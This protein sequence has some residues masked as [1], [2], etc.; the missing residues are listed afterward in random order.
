[1]LTNNII[2]KLTNLNG[3]Y[4]LRMMLSSL[5]TQKSHM[6]LCLLE[7]MISNKLIT[8]ILIHLEIGF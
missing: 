5:E 1:M 7:L 6:V 2:D 8:Y 3:N 4:N